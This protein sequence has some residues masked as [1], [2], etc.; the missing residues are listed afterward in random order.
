MEIQ[1]VKHE[2]ES[3]QVIIKCRELDDEVMRLKCHIELFDQRLQ[4]KKENELQFVNS[5]DVLYFE[6]VDNRTFLYTK[7]AVM[8]V[9]QRLYELEMI[10][11]EKDF[12]RISKS[13][14]VNINK[15]RAL[16]PEL[17]RTLL[18]TMCNGE[19]LSVSRKY[20]KAI[21]NLLSV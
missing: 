7:D 2:K 1:I 11:S 21:R 9:R 8:E 10:L 12:I 17:N 18:A 19:Q 6:S 3:L 14:I 13:Q 15:I 4:A 20:V 16:R 5:S